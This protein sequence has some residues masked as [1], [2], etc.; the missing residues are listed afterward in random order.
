MGRDCGSGPCPI[1]SR[2]GLAARPTGGVVWW[3]GCLPPFPAEWQP[4]LYTF[5]V[6]HRHSA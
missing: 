3:I 1:R 5:A 4:S 6:V 2:A